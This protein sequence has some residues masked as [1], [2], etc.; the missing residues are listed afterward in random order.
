[1]NQ[2]HLSHPLTSQ[3]VTYLPPTKPYV[4]PGEPTE[5]AFNSAQAKIVL[6]VELFNFVIH[7]SHQIVSF[8]ISLFV[9]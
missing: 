7:K 9:K 3:L 2:G 6:P 5:Y 4:I 1:M 8:D